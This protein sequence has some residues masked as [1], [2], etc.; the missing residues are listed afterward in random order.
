MSKEQPTVKKQEKTPVIKILKWVGVAAICILLVLYFV[1]SSVSETGNNVVV[2]KVNGKPVYYSRGSDFAQNYERI[3]Q[4]M[5]LSAYDGEIRNLLVGMIEYQAFTTT[6][7]QMLMYEVAKKNI[8]ITDE[9]L[10]NSIKGS[11]VSERGVFLASEYENFIKN[12]NAVEKKVVVENARQQ[13]AIRTLGHELFQTVKTSSMLVDAE[14]AKRNNKRSIEV[15]YANAMPIVRDYLPTDGEVGMYFAENNT[16]F[17]QADISW[18][19]TSSQSEATLIYDT[20]KND[21]ANFA[22]MAIDKSEDSPTAAANGKVGKLTRHEMPSVAIAEAVFAATKNDTLL[23]PL[24]FDG[25]YYIIVVHSTSI[26]SSASEVAEHVIF[27]EYL[28]AHSDSILIKVKADLKE[29][30][31]ADYANAANSASLSANNAYSYYAVNDFHYG[32]VA[33][34]AASGMGISFSGE[35]LFSDTAFAT[36][37]GATSE[38]VE[39]AEGVA[40]INVVAENKAPVVANENATQEELIALEQMRNEAA[41]YIYS[42]K[43]NN[44]A[45][46]WTE[47]AMSKAKIEYKLNK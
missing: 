9:Y 3:S 27:D 24:Y 29:Q 33:T 10:E 32:S 45:Q 15:V 30:L 11:F 8:E 20:V 39:L 2:G 35:K 31:A 5:N 42:Q 22:Q 47:I 14:F 17:V 4:S 37:V 1:F 13:I 46:K 40:I 23:E 38:V 16:N 18:I 25:A 34:N 21:M 28:K 43:A 6:A 19:V 36:A 41:N 44:L 12:R 26:P 7:N